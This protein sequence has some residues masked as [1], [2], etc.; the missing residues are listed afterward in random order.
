MDWNVGRATLQRIG[1][2]CVLVAGSSA[3]SA[4]NYLVGNGGACQFTT[5]QAAV[6]AAKANPGADTVRVSLGSYTAQ[7]IVI[8]ADSVTLEGGYESCSSAT[9]TSRTVLDGSGGSA[10]TVV[11][12]TGTGNNVT[13]RH[14]LIRGGDEVS[15]GYG[16]GVSAHRAQLAIEHVE[17]SNNVAG[18]GGGI[19][20]SETALTLR[21]DV[22]IVGNRATHAG[23]GIYLGAASLRAEGNDLYIGF[24]DA[25]S[26]NGGG[27]AAH[28]SNVDIGARGD[29]AAPVLQGNRAGYGGAISIVAGDFGIGPSRVRLY[30]LDPSRPVRLSGNVASALGG[31]VY[32][33]PSYDIS[34]PDDFARATLCASDFRFDDNVAV[35][36]TAIYVDTAYA[37]GI[38]PH[39]GQVFL[40]TTGDCFGV[41]ARP[42]QAVSCSG[43]IGCNWIDDNLADDGSGAV[44][45]V[46]NGGELVARRVTFRGNTGGRLVNAFGDYD[47]E[48]LRFTS[49]RLDTCLIADNDFGLEM[50]RMHDSKAQLDLAQCTVAGNAVGAAA[51]A[52]FDGGEFSRL[53]LQRSVVAQTGKAIVQGTP[54]ERVYADLVVHETTSLPGA[55]R[56]QQADARF[57]DPELGDYRLQAASPAVDFAASGTASELF[58]QSRPRDLPVVIDAHGRYDLGAYER[59]AVG[60]LVRNPDFA[61][62]PSQPTMPFRLWS[63]VNPAY[64]EWEAAG[65]DAAEGALL[66]SYEPGIDP[67]PLRGDVAYAGLR[68]CVLIPG[69]AQYVLNGY[70]R[71]PGN[72]MLRDYARL[73]WVFRSNDSSCSG[74]ATTEGVHYLPRSASWSTGAAG[75]IPVGPELWSSNSSIEIVTEV[76]DGNDLGTDVVN[77]Y[78]DRISLT[79]GDL[80]VPE[81][82]RD[83]F[84]N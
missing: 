22:R 32:L 63:V 38:Y 64:V 67:T 65:A 83:G 46:Q 5:V 39:S 11:A 34:T 58:N 52:R 56:I 6:N 60:N 14:L 41:P 30:S 21:D 27:I 2:C 35:E 25:G 54:E 42:P 53:A 17:I 26:G 81:L 57:F 4:A 59:Q 33:I 70:S 9:P 55:L 74:P 76:L 61:A 10:D 50:F 40:N 43:A 71:V 36:G 31:A 48:A 20:L 82:F 16:G 80:E 78:F 66:V 28:R 51:L 75:I 49:V 62:P 19:Y 13:L 7:A 77:A 15:D 37:L 79:V 47:D 29:A 8:N 68:T 72:Q 69:P 84:E 3:A 23:G 12:I 45:T 44:L 1:A 24:N 73:R 18:T